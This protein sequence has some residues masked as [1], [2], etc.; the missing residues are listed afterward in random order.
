LGRYAAR[1]RDNGDSRDLDQY[2]DPIRL[3]IAEERRQVVD[4]A[5]RRLTGRDSEILL[6]KYTE[7]WSYRQLSEHLGISESAVDGRLQRARARLRHELVNLGL[8]EELD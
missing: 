7:Y 2:A 3:L 1:C 6:L 5:L 8:A 4:Q